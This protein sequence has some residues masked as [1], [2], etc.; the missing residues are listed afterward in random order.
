M[1]TI[2]KPQIGQA[3]IRRAVKVLKSGHLAQGE[4][5]RELERAFASYCGTRYAVAVNSGTAAIHAGLYAFGVGEGDEVITS[6]FSFIASVSPI[7]IQGARV[8]FADIRESDF[9]LDP[10]SVDNHVS[11]NT[12]VIIPIDLYGRV[13][14]HPAIAAI[15]RKNNLRILEDACQAIGAHIRGRKAGTF[16]DAAAFSLYATK[17][18]TC[19]E[20][21]VLTTNDRAI[22][23]RARM[24]RNHGQPE[25]KR[26]EYVDIGYNYR[27]TDIQAAIAIEQLKKVDRVNVQRIRNAQLLSTMLGTN[28]ALVVPQVPEGME[29]VFHQYTIRLKGPLA[30]RRDG[31]V[32]YL[33]DR[34]I[35]VGIY[36]PRPL[37]LSPVFSRLG[38]RAGDCPVAERIA[39]EVVSIPVH[40]GLTQKD[41][42]YIAESILEYVG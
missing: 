14:D 23:D 6:P 31:L 42:S 10:E 36:Y 25:G 41:V 39:G 1:L 40:P 28:E 16:G 5:V 29:H 9:C 20:G 22:A 27:M 30:A 15:A 4:E 37:H 24:F 34:G 35:S 19:G 3:E 38:Y 8:V 11:K 7:L 33:H 17:N 18:I 32:K 21:G 2:S 12:K 13:Y 26:Y